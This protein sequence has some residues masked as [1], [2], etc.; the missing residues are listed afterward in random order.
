MVLLVRPT[1]TSRLTSSGVKTCTKCDKPGEF[2]EGRRVC[3]VC[4]R[5]YNRARYHI[6]HSR[7]RQVK[8][9]YYERNKDSVI[10]ASRRSK[11][12]TKYGLTQA[13]VDEM[14]LSQGGLCAICKKPPSG[15]Y[16]N[17]KLHIDHSHKTGTIRAMLCSKC[18]T[19]LG[20]VG[21]SVEVLH[22]MIYYLETH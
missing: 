20:L 10:R 19:A 15:T 21:E 16:A 11:L 1:R 5:S 9:S 17:A 7:M 14:T 4:M 3:K 6:A 12:K 13:Q 8:N 22:M 2:Y 18:N